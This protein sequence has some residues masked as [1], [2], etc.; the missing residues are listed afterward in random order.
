ML[1]LSGCT[2]T[3][4]LGTPTCDPA[5]VGTGDDLTAH[6]VHSRRGKGV[7][8]YAPTNGLRARAYGEYDLSTGDLWMATEF[9]PGHWRT[10][11]EATG[12]GTAW[13]DG[14]LD[15][16]YT[17]TE[18]RM[19]ETI[20]VSRIR[21]VRVGCEQSVHTS[22]DG[23]VVGSD[24]ATWADGEWRGTRSFMRLG[25]A[26]EAERRVDSAGAWE[27]SWF[28]S[29]DVSTL[30]VTASGDGAGVWEERFDE[31][32]RGT[33]S[34]GVMA[35]DVAGARAYA[36]DVMADG[37]TWSWN[38]TLDWYGSGLGSVTVDEGVSCAVVFTDGVCTA[39]CPGR[40]PQ[41][42]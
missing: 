41:G 21:H 28:H 36:Y 20:S 4:E 19:D 32:D 39:T 37:A 18:A 26:V 23:E 40:A 2:P 24:V 30:H 25:V 17:L 8:D 10:V 13:S 12:E 11:S 5:M 22:V 34:I 38:Y 16:A 7:W 27:E 9:V 14:D 29:D 3:F 35:V 42:C 33:R 1:L 31:A 6:L 15:L